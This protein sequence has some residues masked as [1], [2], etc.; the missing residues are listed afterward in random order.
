M[1]SE[2]FN[3][4]NHKPLISIVTV[5]FNSEKTI[6]RT[7]ESVLN[8]TYTNIEYRIVDGLSSDNT[9]SI[10]RGYEEA[11]RKKGI[12][13]SIISEKDNGIY[14]AMNKGI[15]LADGEII[16]MINADDWYEPVAAQT[17]AETYAENPFDCFYADLNL[18]HDDGKITVKHSKEDKRPS[19]R[20]WNHPTTFIT[21]RTYNEEGLYACRCI[22]DDWDMMLRLRK[23]NKR[24][25]VKNVV[26]A[27]FTLNGISHKKSL[28]EVFRRAKIKYSCYKRNGYGFTYYLAECLFIETAKFI[29]G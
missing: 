11:F 22:Y 9:I 19:T 21:K 10:C 4:E 13:Y 26:L 2:D 7:I 15:T 18:V 16:G 25:T 14:D 8:Q 27:N 3:P 17:V 24:V 23:A 6:G 29:L 5:S 20:H 1:K 28:K 12:K